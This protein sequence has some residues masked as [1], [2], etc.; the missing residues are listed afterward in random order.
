MLRWVIY[1]VI[2]SL[3]IPFIDHAG[4]FGGLLTGFL[5]GLFVP[6][7]VTSD[8]ARRWRIPCWIAIVLCSVALGFSVWN[9]LAAQV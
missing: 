9:L 6:R 7:Y 5:F 2:F 1:L 3:A 8:I 4:H